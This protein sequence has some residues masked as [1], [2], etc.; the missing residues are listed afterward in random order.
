MFI[1]LFQMN[2]RAEVSYGGTHGGS[3]CDGRHILHMVEVLPRG[4]GRS[5][6]LGIVIDLFH[7]G[8]E[9]MFTQVLWDLC[10]HVNVH[11]LLKAIVGYGLK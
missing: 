1:C 2:V 3:G 5:D 9:E 11:K 4:G 10:L 7:E 6:G 8:Q